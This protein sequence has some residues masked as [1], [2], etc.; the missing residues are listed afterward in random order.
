MNDAGQRGRPI[1]TVVVSPRDSF[2]HSLRCLDRLLECTPEPRRIVYVDG[3][4]PVPLARELKARAR[5]ADLALL[6]TDCVLAPNR[7]RNLALDLARAPGEPAWTA[8]VDHDTYVE[9]GWLESLRACGEETG[10]AAVVPLLCIG[11]NERQRIHVAAGDAAIVD[12][13]R[14]RRFEEAH[15]FLDQPVLPARDDM[16]RQRCTMF[17]FHGV[18][19][20]TDA[21][22]AVTPLDEGLLSLFEHVDLGF[23]LRERGGDIWFEPSVLITYLPGAVSSADARRY[24]VTRWSDDWNDSTVDRFREKWDLAPGDAKT[25]QNVEFAAWMRA[26]AYRP[27]RSPF[28]RWSA[29]RGRYPRS[30]VDRV[31]QRDALRWYRRQVAASGP[32]RLVH[33]PTWLEASVD[34]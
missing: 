17:E 29:R 16:Q 28:V 24:F 8:F 4:S 1:A 20:R 12:D 2:T 6:R 22:R 19:V 15:P 23:A 18:L 7:A 10:A 31:A 9:P 5:A 30:L 27:Y 26:R 21:L 25:A 34:A 11:E 33:R 32:P 13:G 3:G 14:G